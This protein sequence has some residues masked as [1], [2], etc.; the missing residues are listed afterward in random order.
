MDRNLAPGFRGWE[1]QDPGLVPWEAFLLHPQGRRLVWG[2]HQSLGA[3]GRGRGLSPS[4]CKEPTPVMKVGGASTGTVPVSEPRLQ[5]PGGQAQGVVHCGSAALM[6]AL[7][8]PA[9]SSLGF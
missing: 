6:Q 4:F 2:D 8:L 3:W 9:C 1:V 7:G 5:C